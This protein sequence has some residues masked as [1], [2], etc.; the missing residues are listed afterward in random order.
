MVEKLWLGFII[1]F[2]YL[3]GSV[4]VSIIISKLIGT[5]IR[6]HGSGNA[7]ATNM[8]RT[9]GKV[10]GVGVLFLDAAKGL[11]ACGV[12]MFIEHTLYK[13]GIASEITHTYKYMAALFVVVGHNY[14][15]FFG[16]KGGKGISTSGAVM[17][18]LDWRAGLVVLVGALA[19]MAITRYVS[20]G[21]LVGAVLY[22]LTPLFFTYIV[23]KSENTVFILVCAAMGV[24]A[25]YR[26][27]KNIVRLCKGTESKIGSKSKNKAE[28]EEK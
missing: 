20:L 2:A 24:L 11:L 10:A 28:S 23:D 18:M 7:G 16:F 21:S 12:A 8:L 17:F 6:R 14:P 22:I 5:D 27:W 4:N 25:I 19:V 1:V 9:Y 26:H 13:M 3:I 15:I